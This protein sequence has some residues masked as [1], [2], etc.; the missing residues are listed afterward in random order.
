MY[1]PFTFLN[2]YSGGGNVLPGYAVTL[3]PT[4]CLLNACKKKSGPS[5]NERRLSPVT[6][7]SGVTKEVNLPVPLPFPSEK[8]KP[9]HETAIAA[10]AYTNYEALGDDRSLPKLV[11]WYQ[12]RAKSNQGEGLSD[13]YIPSLSTLKRWS[14]MHNWQQ[15]LKDYERV[16]L[17]ERRKKRQKELEDMDKRHSDYGRAALYKAIE[18]IEGHLNDPG[19][20]VAQAV[21]LM[22]ASYELERLARGAATERIEGDMTMTI[23]PK[24]YIN[25]DPDECGSEP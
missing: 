2:G 3:V 10:A 7:R 16:Q 8:R 21:S 13:T 9:L 11:A 22:R 20:T 25:V 1:S 18:Y 19:T 17:D 23:L 5:D 14:N 24:E 12:R 6:E 4:R 15:R